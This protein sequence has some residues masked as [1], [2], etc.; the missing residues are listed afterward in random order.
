MQDPHMSNGF[1]AQGQ[2]VRWKQAQAVD[3]GSEG[4]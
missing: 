4:C 3:N 1:Y 2:L